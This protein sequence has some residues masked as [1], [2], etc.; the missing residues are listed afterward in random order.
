M[1]DFNKNTHALEFYGETGEIELTQ[2][3]G[4]KAFV[5]WKNKFDFLEMLKSN[6]VFFEEIKKLIVEDE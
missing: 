1:V 4:P 2:I 3:N 6:D 5:Y